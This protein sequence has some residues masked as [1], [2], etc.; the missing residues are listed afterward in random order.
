MQTKPS[1]I[2]EVIQNHSNR[3]ITDH[4]LA[5]IDEHFAKRQGPVRILLRTAHPP[6]VLRCMRFLSSVMPTTSSD[7]VAML[8]DDRGRLAVA[9]MLA[10]SINSDHQISVRAF[11]KENRTLALGWLCVGCHD[12]PVIARRVMG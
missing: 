1:V 2:H 4:S 7:R 6:N 5:V 11:H 8:I 12:T 3:N 10:R 9:Q